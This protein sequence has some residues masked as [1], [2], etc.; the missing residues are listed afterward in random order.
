MKTFA[1]QVENGQSAGGH[2]RNEISPNENNIFTEIGKRRIFESLKVVGIILVLLF[3]FKGPFV[4]ITFLVVF[5]F[6][7][8]HS[9][10]FVVCALT[11]INSALNPFVYSWKIDTIRKEFKSFFRLCRMTEHPPE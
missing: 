2:T 10:I 3:L 4:T 7:P 5:N 8:S 11:S 6:N 1:W 9:A